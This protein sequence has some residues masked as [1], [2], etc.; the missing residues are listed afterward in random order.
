MAN[1]VALMQT[2]HSMDV[3]KVSLHLDLP[4]CLRSLALVLLLC[5]LVEINVLHRTLDKTTLLVAPIDQD[6][7]TLST[8]LTERTMSKP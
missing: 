8:V 6:D 1:T 3:Q 2:T 4:L 5:S 7:F